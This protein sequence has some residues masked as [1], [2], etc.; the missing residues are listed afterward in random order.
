ML[1]V[2]Q[3][4]R[5]LVVRTSL[6]REQYRTMLDKSPMTVIGTQYLTKHLSS[7]NKLGRSVS[8]LQTKAPPIKD[9]YVDRW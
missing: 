4:S 5:C 1:S 8:A 9:R 6:Q 7:L 3:L 2:V